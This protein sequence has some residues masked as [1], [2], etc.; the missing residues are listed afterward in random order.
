MADPPSSSTATTESVVNNQLAQLVPTFDPSTDSVEAWGQKVELLFAAWPP[1]KLQELAR[2]ILN[3]KGT[4]AF[5]KPQL[6][7]QKVLTGD[8][9]SI[10]RII[11]IVGGTFGQVPLWRK[12]TRPLR[13]QFTDAS[14]RQMSRQIRIWSEQMWCGPNCWLR[15]Q[16]FKKS[17]HMPSSED[18]DLDQKIRNS[19]LVESGAE[20][21][22]ALEMTQVSAAEDVGIQFLPRAT[23]AKREKSQKTCDQTAFTVEETDDVEEVHWTWH[24]EGL[25]EEVIEA[26]AAQEDEDATLIMQF[27]GAV[28]ESPRRCRLSCIFS[29]TE[30]TKMRG[31]WPIKGLGKKGKKGYGKG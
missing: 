14:R 12:S 7:Q 22:G 13:R 1:S 9:Q 23:G 2:V 4:H 8:K 27:E 6:R 29:L 26:L 3:T 31:F 11:E 5:Q 19:V 21:G 25:S 15:R 10:K 16:H 18:A 24:D 28:M 17:K 30:R 20:R